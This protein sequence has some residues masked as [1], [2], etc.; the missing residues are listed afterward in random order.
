MSIVAK[1]TPESMTVSVPT[2][3]KIAGISQS[4]AY[5]LIKV[6]QFPYRRI[7]HRVVVPLRLLH[8]WI[9]HGACTGIEEED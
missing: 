2:A 9:E 1:R 6:D 4:T 8:I 7:G 5:R 3:S